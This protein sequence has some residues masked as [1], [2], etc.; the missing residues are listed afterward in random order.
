[1]TYKKIVFLLLLIASLLSVPMLKAQASAGM[2]G[3]VTDSSGAIVA[4]AAITLTNK[5]TGLKFTQTTNSAGVYRF[6]DIPPG[7]G[8]EVVFSAPGFSPLDVKDLYLTVASIRTQNATL[9]VGG[10]VSEVEVT[11]SNSEV[12]ID[13][14]SAT[15]ARRS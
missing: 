7:Q 14:T 3:T 13:T 15:I 1:M 2:T 6:S 12:T 9:T 8:Y 10:N 5:T 4:N 11:A